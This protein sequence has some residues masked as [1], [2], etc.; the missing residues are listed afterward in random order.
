MSQL[1]EYGDQGCLGNKR[2]APQIIELLHHSSANDQDLILVPNDTTRNNNNSEFVLNP[3]LSPIAA[4]EH[5]SVLPAG[6]MRR[7]TEPLA[8][9]SFGREP[10]AL[11]SAT[12]YDPISGSLVTDMMQKVSNQNELTSLPCTSTRWSMFNREEPDHCWL[13]HDDLPSLTSCSSP[14]HHWFPRSLQ[15]HD[16]VMSI[17]PL[18]MNKPV[19]SEPRSLCPQHSSPS[20]Y[21]VDQ[22]K[23]Q[24][25]STV[26]RQICKHV[27]EMDSC[28]SA[29]TGEL[30][31]TVLEDSLE[32]DEE[33]VEEDEEM[34][35]TDH[36][37][38]EETG[39][40]EYND[41]TH[42]IKNI[43]DFKLGI[44]EF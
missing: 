31:C 28:Q 19:H 41:S 42:P 6:S 18:D 29:T 8:T 5:F 15:V 16:N 25:P 39:N 9:K 40:E 43:A 11:C 21:I 17:T 13:P 34:L 37:S 22:E 33:T 38:V 26:T 24:F 44:W 7:L 23:H 20:D 4:G 32:E 2:S 10:V 35:I 12:M 1:S 27:V 3:E 36:L 30:A 14:V